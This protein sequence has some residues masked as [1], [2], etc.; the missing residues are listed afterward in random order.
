MLG[1]VLGGRVAPVVVV[2]MEEQAEV[3]PLSPVL[4]EG[5]DPGV[6]PVPPDL[7]LLSPYG[8]VAAELR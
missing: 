1:V 8:V 4:E 7:V 6:E 3:W 2:V 5:E